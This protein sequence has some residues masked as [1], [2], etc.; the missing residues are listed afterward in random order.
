MKKLLLIAVVGLFLTSCDKDQKA[1]EDIASGTW[2][3][4]ELTNEDGENSFE[5]FTTWTGTATF[6][7]CDQENGDCTGKMVYTATRTTQE[8]VGGGNTEPLIVNVDMT[9][10]FTYSIS[11]KGTMI[12]V[13]TGASVVNSM[14]DFMGN[15]Q[16]GTENDICDSDC[17]ADG[18]ISDDKTKISLISDDGGTIK[19]EKN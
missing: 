5:D 11:E 8:D 14:S 18:T 17:G 12:S 3:V 7:E 9:I 4:T 10:N 2:I 1:L 19:M 15:T 16:S 13:E 6:D